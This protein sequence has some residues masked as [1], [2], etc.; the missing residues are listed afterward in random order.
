MTAGCFISWNAVTTALTSPMAGTA[1]S[2]VS[3]TV[4]T[5]LQ[6]KSPP[7]S[8]IRII[9]WGYLFTTS[10]TSPV[11]VELVETGAVFATVTTGSI[12]SYNDVTGSASLCPTGTTSTGY[13]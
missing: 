5:I 9:E 7:S 10:P 3:G 11:Q 8:K 13:N 1:T 2:A 4:K 6:V 12:S